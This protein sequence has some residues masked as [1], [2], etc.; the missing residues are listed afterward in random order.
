M[1]SGKYSRQFRYPANSLRLDGAIQDRPLR[2]GY[3]YLPSRHGNDLYSCIGVIALMEENDGCLSPGSRTMRAE[4]DRDLDA[5][6]AIGRKPV[7][8]GRRPEPDVVL[9]LPDGKGRPG[10]VDPEASG[11]RR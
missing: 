1:A 11:L 3:M 5:A 8:V 2:A 9:R 6:R 7:L 4:G 10:I